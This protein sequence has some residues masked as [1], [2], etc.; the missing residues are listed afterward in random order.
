M[1]RKLSS[2]FTRFMQ[3]LF[4]YV[5]I[6]QAKEGLSYEGGDDQVALHV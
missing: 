2:D 3:R 6:E 5:K 1:Q 4:E